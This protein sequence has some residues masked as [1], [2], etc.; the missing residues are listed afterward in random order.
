MGADAEGRTI[1][2][3]SRT[4]NMSSACGEE[5]E[6]FFLTP[7]EVAVYARRANKNG[8]PGKKEL[9]KYLSQAK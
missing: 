1:L 6:Y 9:K 5:S 4:V 7:E 2:H 8:F 3:R